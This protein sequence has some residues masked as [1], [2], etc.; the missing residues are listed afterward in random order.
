M[1]LWFCGVD[2]YCYHWVEFEDSKGQAGQRQEDQGERASGSLHKLTF[3]FQ[4]R[5]R[6]SSGSCELEAGALKS[7]QDESR[8]TR[9]GSG[10]DFTQ[11]NEAK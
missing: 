4:P 6:C 11:R 9:E 5:S 3:G 10:I 1:T 2:A 8:R 7:R